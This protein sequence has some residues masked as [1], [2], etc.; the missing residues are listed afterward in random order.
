MLSSQQQCSAS[1]WTVQNI[2]NKNIPEC[3]FLNYK[4]GSYAHEFTL[5]SITTKQPIIG[6]TKPCNYLD[7]TNQQLTKPPPQKKHYLT[8][9]ASI[10][11]ISMYCKTII[12]ATMVAIATFTNATPVPMEEVSCEVVYK[13]Q[14]YNP[15]PGHNGGPPTHLKREPATIDATLYGGKF[16][17]KREPAA[18]A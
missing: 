16:Y 14:C 4:T 1:V 11:T 3:D 17:I 18:E 10:T 5:I 9:K 13:G 2:R 7:I 6:K 15:T 8:T 12:A